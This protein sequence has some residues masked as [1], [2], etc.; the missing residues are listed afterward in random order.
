MSQHAADAQRILEARARISR[1]LNIE[2]QFEGVPGA[3]LTFVAAEAQRLAD[4]V[5]VMQ[6]PTGV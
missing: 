5:E 3:L 1:A 4:L 2:R 6:S